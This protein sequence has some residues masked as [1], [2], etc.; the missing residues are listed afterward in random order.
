MMNVVSRFKRM[1][2]ENKGEFMYSKH[3]TSSTWWVA[4][5]IYAVTFFLVTLTFFQAA[6]AEKIKNSKNT[7]KAELKKDEKKSVGTT[8]GKEM[9]VVFETT[10]GSFKVKLNSEKAPKSVEN[11]LKYVDEG[12]FNGTIFHRVIPGFMIQGGGFTSALSQKTTHEPIKNEANNGLLNKRG[13]L[14]MARTMDP[15]SA[16]AQFFVNLVDNSFLDFKEES[17]RGWGYAVFAEVV[18]GM[19]IVD[20][21]AKE[22]TSRKQDYDDVPVKTIEIKSAKRVTE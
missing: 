18:E 2:L 5:W 13:T 7:V 21:I 6:N 22:P 1:L 17:M 9:F 3:R 11:F 4:L 19:E 8:K 12:F 16:T 15:H 10:L 14:A 20:K